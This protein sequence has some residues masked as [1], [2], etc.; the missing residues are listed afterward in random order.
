MK[1]KTNINWYPG[2]M[3][4]TKRELKE[5]MKYIDLVYEVIDARMPISSRVIDLD[6]IIKDKPKIIIVTK[7]DLCDVKKTDQILE[8]EYNNDIVVKCD[9]LKGNLNEILNK[10]KEV[11]NSLNKIREEKGMLSSKIRVLVVGAPNVGKST[12]INRLVG[13][14]SQKTGN[15]P[16]VTRNLN[17]IRINDNIELLDSPGIL[18]PKLANDEV[19]QVLAVLSSIKEEI[20]DKEM[21]ASFI[22]DKLMEL[23]PEKLKER[24]KLEELD[25]D[26]IY[27]DIG[28]NRGL[29]QRGGIIDYDRV[30]TTIIQDIKT[31]LINNITLDSL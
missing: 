2:H 18:Y 30:F 16:G 11:H 26:T 29:I 9:L 10:T 22:I 25:K 7:Y 12:L 23:Y 5:N 6:E 1:N 3:A 15:Q 4:K 31:G 13:R 20:L 28:K 19:A 24:Y 14:K 21:I 17:W 27:D 8:K